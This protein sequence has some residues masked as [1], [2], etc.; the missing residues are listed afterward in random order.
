MGQV[1]PLHLLHLCPPAWLCGTEGLG[2]KLGSHVLAPWLLWEQVMWVHEPQV[3]CYLCFE[4]LP[5][6]SWL[7]L[8]QVTGPPVDC[9]LSYR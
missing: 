7:G 6:A 8:G 1:F 5:I 2:L 3:R 4:A 9:F